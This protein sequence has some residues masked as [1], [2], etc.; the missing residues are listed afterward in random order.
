MNSRSIPIRR[1]L[2]VYR[3]PQRTSLRRRRTHE[4]ASL[5]NG[6]HQR[7]VAAHLQG[8]LSTSHHHCDRNAPPSVPA[9]GAMRIERALRREAHQGVFSSRRSERRASFRLGWRSPAF[10][11]ATK[12]SS[13]R[14]P[15]SGT[16][17][18][19]APGPHNRPALRTLP[20]PGILRERTRAH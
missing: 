18:W 10:R 9:P 16:R 14:R 6:A 13:T 15:F 7:S 11:T 20:G 5:G 8:L 17:T 2:L 1:R 12:G 3:L 4:A 19:A